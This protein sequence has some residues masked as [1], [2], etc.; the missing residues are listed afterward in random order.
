MSAVVIC[1]LVAAYTD[2]LY[3]K[4]RSLHIYSRSNSNVYFQLSSF[5]SFGRPYHVLKG[6]QY[7]SS[8]GHMGKVRT[9]Y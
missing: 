3:P 9:V 4:P 2:P 6:H 7:A 1:V 8:E 5:R